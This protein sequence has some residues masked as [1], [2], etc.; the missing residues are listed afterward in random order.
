MIAI[1]GLDEAIIGTGIR[2]SDSEVL[3]YDADAAQE[4][5]LYLG[6]GENAL[7]YFLESLNV[8]GLGDKAPIFI[9]LDNNLAKNDSFNHDGRPKLRIV[10]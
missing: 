10:H 4:V 7:P 9:Y 6:Y 8:D 2:S 5:L 1:E 3:V